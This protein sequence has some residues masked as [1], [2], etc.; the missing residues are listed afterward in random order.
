MLKLREAWGKVRHCAAPVTVVCD[1]LCGLERLPECAIPLG[2]RQDV[3]RNKSRE[4][5][6]A[7]LDQQATQVQAE[8]GQCPLPGG[9]LLVCLIAQPQGPLN[10]S[11]VAL[12]IA[13]SVNLS[14]LPCR[15]PTSAQH[16]RQF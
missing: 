13:E 3:A 8:V 5:T 6:D 4:T 7:G 11:Q 9:I 16:L 2:C 10:V 12:I 14:P 15:T 1:A